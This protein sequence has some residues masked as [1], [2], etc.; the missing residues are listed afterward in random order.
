M[1]WLEVQDGEDRVYSTRKEAQRVADEL[2]THH[3]G[4]LG[5]YPRPRRPA[6]RIK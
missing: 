6:R 4:P 1:K 5:Y 3:G 2:T